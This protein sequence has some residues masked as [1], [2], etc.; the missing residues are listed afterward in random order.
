MIKSDD[1]R[2]FDRNL[3]I[4]QGKSTKVFYADIVKRIKL[5]FLGKMDDNGNINTYSY[6]STSK[7]FSTGQAK[8]ENLIVGNNILQDVIKIYSEM[9]SDKK[10]IIQSSDEKFLSQFAVDRIVGETVFTNAYAGSVLLK[11]V[12]NQ[13][14]KEFSFYTIKRNEFFEVHNE[15]NP[16]L[17]DSY[18]VFERIQDGILKC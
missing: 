6:D 8:F 2:N 15:F 14:T 10:P 4:A 11:G 17:V 16:E 5:E 9:A 3:K 18:V 1:Y 13:D 7:S 12:V